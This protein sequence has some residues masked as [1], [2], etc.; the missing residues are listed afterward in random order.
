MQD[1]AIDVARQTAPWKEGQNWWVVG[2]EG[3]VALLVGVYIVANPEGASDIIRTLVALVLLALSLGQ[4]EEG[5]RFRGLPASPWSTL[6]GGIGLAVA[7]LALLSARSDEV[8]LAGAR[9]MLAAGL[10]A[11]GVIGI[12]S[13]LFTLRTAGFRAA[14]IIPDI[15]T[16]VLGILL[17]SARTDDTSGVRWLG[18][19]AI[20]GGIA[21]LIYAYLLQS[22]TRARA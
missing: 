9:Q 4:I 1:I 6:R 3:I 2:I 15:L 11:Y 21:L 14:V 13:L 16:I 18:W 22:R 20:V 7:A 17:L 10:L 19:A 5:F 12:V 8:T